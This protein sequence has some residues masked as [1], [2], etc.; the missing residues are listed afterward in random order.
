MADNYVT[1]Q[2]KASDTAKPDLTD[3]KAQ[4]DEL[5]A[6]VDT[7]QVKVDDTDAAQKLLDINAKLAAL[8]AKVANPKISVSGAARAQA[9]IAALKTEMDALGGSSAT[10]KSRLTDLGGAASSLTGLGDAFTLASGES[11]MFQKV[12][13]GAGLATGLFEPVV[14]G[15]TVAAGGLASGLVS[16]GAGLGVFGLVAK[17][18]YSQAQ[19]ALTSYNTAQNTTGKAASTAM[20]KYQAE[21]AALPPSQQAFV[22]SIEG[23]EN[24]WQN[25]VSNNT[26]G[27]TKILNQGMGLLPKILS[28]IQPL[29]APTEKA[30][31][32]IIDKLSK[33]LD[34]SGFKSFMD[35]LTQNT[36][37]AIEKIAT[38]IGHVVE[39]IGGILKAFMPVSQGLLSGLD[40]ITAKFAKWGETLGSH[41]GFQSMMQTF[42]TETPIAMQILK[43]L[44]EVL[45][46]VG[47]G[48][49]GL[50][51]GSNSKTLLQVLEPLSG[52]LAQLS[53]NQDLVR[54]GLYLLAA[55]DAGKKLHSAVQGVSNVMTGFKAGVDILGKFGGAA[56]DAGAGAKIASAATKVWTGIQAAFNAVMD[57][58]PIILVVAAIA[59]LV[60]GI[61]YAYT[62]FKTFRDIV[63]DVGRA[64]KTGFMD[65]FNWVKGAVTDVVDFIKTH[66]EMLLTIFTGPIGL[67][68][69]FLKTHWDQIVSDVSSFVSSVTNFISGLV[70][71]VENFFTS[72]FTSLYNTE[73]NGW[74]NIVNAVSTFVSDVVNFISGL[75]TDVVNF[76]TSLWTQVSSAV[77]TGIGNVINWFSQLPGQIIS[78]ISALPAELYNAGQNLISGLWNGISSMGGWLWSLVTGFVE[79]YI[80]N[81]AK[82]LLGI[83]SPSKVFHG[84]GVNIAEGLADGMRAGTWNVR[85]AAA[86]MVGATQSTGQVVGGVST[87]SYANDGAPLQLQVSSGG[88]TA[89]E[90]F[91]CQAI[92]NYVRVRGGNVQQ[93][94]GH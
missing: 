9:Q 7:A 52:I 29:L 17:S 1:I 67:V 38:A 73:K 79:N 53:K 19:T 18:A 32:D 72:L 61:I 83:G 35:S 71:T 55:A 33:G 5:G 30:L 86:H 22:K 4:L 93:A 60:A 63:D 77:T 41:S 65:A 42:K 56:E 37:P 89:F 31:S 12:M 57:V 84:Y 62:H 10:L 94:F 39:G 11:T 20:A 26:A 36:G 2:I 6:K 58:N 14:A 25:F 24:A 50:A 54:I 76:F 90:Q 8:N 3:L 75:V 44:I 13:A 21:L 51:T 16:A 88:N 81:P 59:L 47:S 70:T 43:N 23:A 15:A 27:V 91:M 34:S 82:S 74:S 68:V 40:T 66:W 48:M 92:R 87:G 80:I 64:L 78:A 28:A 85:D 69:A 49:A 46:N 45:K